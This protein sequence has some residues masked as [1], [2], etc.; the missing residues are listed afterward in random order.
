[1]KKSAKTLIADLSFASAPAVPVVH[2]L[3]ERVVAM[4]KLSPT[5]LAAA[6]GTDHGAEIVR[7]DLDAACLD[8]GTA[9]DDYLRP[10]ASIGRADAG[11][12]TDA[13]YG[14]FMLGEH[15]D[16]ADTER[17]AL[18]LYGAHLNP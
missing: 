9:P 6:M 16:A 18:E 13:Q 11:T 8:A 3:V 17:T 14:R 12:L 2:E 10:W 1:M 4:A 5:D 15:P 7:L